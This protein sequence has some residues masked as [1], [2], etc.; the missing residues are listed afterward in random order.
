MTKIFCL[1]PWI[2]SSIE[3]N[4][5]RTLC[6]YSKTFDKDFGE[7]EDYWNSDEM[8]QIRVSMLKGGAPLPE[9]SACAG[10][11]KTL[12]L[13][14]KTYDFARN[15]E[16]NLLEMTSEDGHFNG[17][18]I[19]LDYRVINTCNLSCRTCN[20]F[21]SSKIETVLKK[22][23]QEHF[24][25]D[26]IEVAKNF[27]E[28][29]RLL[30]SGKV[31]RCYFASGEAFL[32]KEHL[33][34]LEKLIE[35]G[36]AKNIALYYNTNLSYDLK[37][38]KSR[39][40]IFSQFQRVVLAISIDGFGSTGEF[41]RDGL[42]WNRFCRNLGEV[43]RFH[44]L[45]IESLDITLTLPTLLD[46]RPLAKFIHQE[47]IP[48]NINRVFTGDYAT[49][50]SPELLE[51]NDFKKLIEEAKVILTDIDPVFFK[52]FVSFL[53]LYLDE[54]GEG[55]RWTFLELLAEVKRTAAVDDAFAR[56]DI[57]KFYS[58]FPLMKSYLD[59][60]KNALANERERELGPEYLFFEEKLIALGFDSR[61]K[62]FIHT[63]L[64]RDLD[65]VSGAIV[66]SSYPSLL[67]RFLSQGKDNK[68]FKNFLLIDTFQSREGI[69]LLPPFQF[70]LRGRP[71]L[72]HLAPLLD[73]ITKP[74]RGF[75]A[76]HFIAKVDGK[77]S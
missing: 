74:L 26:S 72:S 51:I 50:V 21:F 32:Q 65:T 37:I 34:E 73:T 60:F 7:F 4:G 46:F 12:N 69:T 27:N 43:K 5:K 35:T 22:V 66:V 52:D 53:D 45:S 19:S 18:P 63:A 42:N 31:V 17:E 70:I 9:C 28:F 59:K 1:A 75:L 76:L 33:L 11:V 54:V 23:D 20:S 48:Y 47:G 6:C 3:P 56:E 25:I 24:S 61:A 64:P 8:K 49:L 15:L 2:H 29:K 16:E 67:N 44:F 14:K 68:K 55:G 10:E 71:L 30:H 40:N 58:Q 36:E 57:F 38:L 41:I 62:A 39:E 77:K 13:P